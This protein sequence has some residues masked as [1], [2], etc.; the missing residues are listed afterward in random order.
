V[1]D[2]DDDGGGGGGG[3]G[4]GCDGGDARRSL[5]DGAP[6]RSDLISITIRS[7]W[8]RAHALSADS[9]L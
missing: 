1:R 3:G 8:W 5:L 7:W 4:G 9:Q 6:L 2:D